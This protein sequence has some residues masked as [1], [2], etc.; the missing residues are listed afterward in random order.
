MVRRRSA[1]YNDLGYYG[2]L[3]TDVTNFI[4]DLVKQIKPR[5]DRVSLI[6]VGCGTGDF[7]LIASATQWT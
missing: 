5:G 2:Q 4:A 7:P 6:G 1:V 3:N